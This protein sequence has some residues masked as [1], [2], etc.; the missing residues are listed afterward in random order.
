MRNEAPY[1]PIEVWREGER[2]GT[3]PVPSPPP[4]RGRRRSRTGCAGPLRRSRSRRRR[5]GHPARLA[6]PTR[7]PGAT[8]AP[9]TPQ[10][11]LRGVL[12]HA[13][14]ERLPS[15]PAARRLQA[16]LAY[17]AAR[18][19]SLA[20]DR[21][22]RIAADALG[23]LVDRRLA[24]LFGPG[25][26]PRPRSPGACGSVARRWPV[27]G[28]IDRLAIGEGATLV[29]EYKTG[30]PPGDGPVPEPYAAQLALYRALLREIDP[31]RP[32][33]AFL[34]WTAGPTVRELT[35]AELDGALAAV[36]AAAAA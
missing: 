29:A 11:R 28:R 2:S 34:I 31:A 30:A 6:R 18:A 12:V 21:R 23:V 7:R 33:R 16:A 15:V 13:L 24:A 25:S 27:S 17:L 22:D 14:L 10:A 5:C 4:P 1:G 32:V 36:G 19:P 3:A 35:Q 20:P 8:A 9:R 26:G